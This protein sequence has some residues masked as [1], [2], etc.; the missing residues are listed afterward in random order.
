MILFQ[1]LLRKCFCKIQNEK[2]QTG[3]FVPEFTKQ[4]FP[5]NK[6]IFKKVSSLFLILGAMEFTNNSKNNKKSRKD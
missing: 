4:V 3:V 6:I 5:K 1:N 2:L